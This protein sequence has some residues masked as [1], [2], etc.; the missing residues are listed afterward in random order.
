[1]NCLLYALLYGC[2]CITKHSPNFNILLGGRLLA[3]IATSILFSAFESW[4]VHEHFSRG[5]DQ[6]QL[7]RLFS[8]ATLGN[9]LAAIIA[10]LVAQFAADAFGYV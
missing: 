6:I 9:S 5:F 10:G 1:M 4:L 2:S 3:G 8:N 7:S